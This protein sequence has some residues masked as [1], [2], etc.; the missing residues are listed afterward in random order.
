[1]EIFELKN[2]DEKLW[3]E[4]VFNHYNSTFYHQVGWKHVV[5]KSYGHKPYYLLAKE[6]GQIRGVL[7]LFFMKSLFFGRKL[8]SVPFAPY[9]GAVGEKSTVEML[10]ER[11][12]E[13][14]KELGADYLQIRSA[15]SS[16]KLLTNS[17]YTTSILKLDQNPEIVWNDRMTRNK[18]K[19]VVKSKKRN[20]SVNFSNKINEFYNILALNMHEL[21]S[22]VQSKIFFSNILQQFPNSAKIQIVYDGN[23]PIYGAFYLFYKNTIIN[24]WSS[25]LNKYRNYYPTDY[26]I[27]TAIEYGCRNN[28]KNYDFGRSLQGSTNMEFKERW[29]A[30]TQRL[31]YQYYLNRTSK[32]PN[33]TSINP[34][35]KI[36]AKMWKKLPVS[37]T[38]MVGPQLRCKFP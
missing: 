37:L 26:G 28:C 17:V 9:G 14:T 31:Y 20:L 38:K 12:I 25:S 18:R 2:S 36:F 29:G 5:E 15:G 23:K 7:P 10:I 3:N 22:P 34:K 30:E 1:M 8:V 6:D 4:Y 13:L 27:W 11:A 16:S 24:S 32:I 35:R 33:D 19:N 21:G